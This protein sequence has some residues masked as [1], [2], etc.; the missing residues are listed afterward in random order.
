MNAVI[1]DVDGTLVDSVDLHAQAWVAAFARFGRQL[2]FAEVRA[3]IGKGA[4]QLIPHFL[5]REQVASFGDELDRYRTELFVRDYL[6]QVHGFPGVRELFLR[7]RGDG[8]AIALASSAKAEEL[9]HYKHVTGIRDLVTRETSSD[10]ADRS[11]PHPD[12]FEA[13]LARLPRKAR[14]DAIV[15]GDTPWDAIAATR[16]SLRIIGVRCGG[17]PEGEL[18]RAGCIAIYDGPWELL[19]RY[20]SWVRVPIKASRRPEA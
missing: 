14:R 12:I 1:F 15:I 19:R 9:E 10:D 17:F 18:V 7:L 16:A 8:I 4:D 5:T 11:K 20:D 3:Q 6:H 2:D 13:A